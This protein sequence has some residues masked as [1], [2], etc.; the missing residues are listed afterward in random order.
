MKIKTLILLSSILCGFSYA[1]TDL[2][3]S[4]KAVKL[5]SNDISWL[6]TPH[7]EFEE[8]DL[9]GQSRQFLARLYV[10]EMGNVTQVEI[11]KSTSLD[12]LDRKISASLK[13]ARFKPYIENGQAS[14]FITELPIELS[15]RSFT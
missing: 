11:I 2:N 14:P 13:S 12:H 7:I 9:K 8:N 4:P 3:N 15:T 1:D 10:N 6:R 5:Q